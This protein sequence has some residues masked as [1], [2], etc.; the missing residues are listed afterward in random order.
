MLAGF[1]SSFSLSDAFVIVTAT[2]CDLHVIHYP[3]KSFESMMSQNMFPNT[4]SM[5]Y[6]RATV[7]AAEAGEQIV[8]PVL[9]MWPF[10]SKVSTR[11]QISP[12]VQVW[13][14]VRMLVLCSLW[15]IEA[16]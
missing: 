8:K 9:S 7:C 15:T 4:V 12:N 6:G 14:Q 5:A 11:H 10:A 1:K 3:Q 13:I 16:W 2:C